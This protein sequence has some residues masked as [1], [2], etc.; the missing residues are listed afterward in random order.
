MSKNGKVQKIVLF[1]SYSRGEAVDEAANGYY[2]DFD[3]LIIVSQKDMTD[4]A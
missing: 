2:L 3:I 4:V 1:G